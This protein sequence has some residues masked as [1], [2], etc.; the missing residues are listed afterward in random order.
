VCGHRPIKGEGRRLSINPEQIKRILCH[1][2]APEP[3]LSQVKFCEQM[4][5]DVGVYYRA[6]RL[7]YKNQKDIDKVLSVANEIGYDI[8]AA[9]GYTPNSKL[10]NE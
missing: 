9:V 4:R 7:R 6:T 2:I 5:I 8:A 3:K 1:Y 10:V